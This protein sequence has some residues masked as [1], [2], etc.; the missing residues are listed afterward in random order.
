MTIWRMRISC[1]IHHTPNT[2]RICNNY[3]FS[4][5]V[6]RTRLKPEYCRCRSDWAMDWT[7][8][9]S[10][11][12]RYKTFLFSP[13][14]P[15]QPHHLIQRVPRFFFRGVNLTVYLHLVMCLRMNGAIPP[16]LLYVFMARTVVYLTT[17]VGQTQVGFTLFIGHEGP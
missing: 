1:W 4:T 16:L 10:N 6:A 17:L 14:R 13:E 5:I 8:R 12:V 7:G 3:C 11:P 2:L 9:G 15:D